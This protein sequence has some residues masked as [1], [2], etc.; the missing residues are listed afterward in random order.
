[1]HSP[2]MCGYWEGKKMRWQVDQAH[3]YCESVNAQAGFFFCCF[4]M[5]T[6]M[7][8]FLGKKVSRWCLANCTSFSSVEKSQLTSLICLYCWSFHSGLAFRQFM[9]N[10]FTLI[11]RSSILSGNT[12][13]RQQFIFIGD[14]ENTDHYK[15]WSVDMILAVFSAT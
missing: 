1:M 15:L 10:C 12:C 7:L 8:T 5:F 4:Q 2:W 11:S 6:L 9:K 3:G 13:K 14:W